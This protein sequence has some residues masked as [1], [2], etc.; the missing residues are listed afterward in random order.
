MRFGTRKIPY[1]N[2][3]PSSPLLPGGEKARLRGTVVIFCFLVLAGCGWGGGGTGTDIQPASPVVEAPTP[4][5]TATLTLS[6]LE[7]GD[8]ALSASWQNVSA[9]SHTQKT[10]WLMP[11][12][13]LYRER[14]QEFSASPVVTTLAVAGTHITDRRLFGAWR[15]EVVI[16]NQPAPGGSLTFTIGG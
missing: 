1:P 15:V 12:G 3:L 10:R 9:G 13:D 8:L 5:P 4:E 11:N 7:G 2:P 16:D 14:T 6:T